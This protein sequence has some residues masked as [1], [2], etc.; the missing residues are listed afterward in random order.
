M[1][2]RN[3]ACIALG[4][5]LGK[6]RKAFERA[7]AMLR[8]CGVE[9]VRESGLWRSPAWPAESGAPDY[10]NAVVAVETELGA[11]ALMAMLHEVEAAA[12]RVRGE[13]N[14]PRE[15]DLDLVCYGDEVLA[16]GRDVGLVLPHPRMADRAFVL[17]PLWEV[18]GE[19]WRHPV[20]GEGVWEMMGRLVSVE[21]ERVGPAITT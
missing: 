13:R 6:P 10:L 1:T 14:A 7:L 16:E 4:A 8:Q 5:N 12:G 3:T 15:L 2:E 9:V 17:L 11:H 21:C 18:A 20:S 19:A